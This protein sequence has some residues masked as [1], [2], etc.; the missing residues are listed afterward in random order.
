MIVRAALLL[1][2][3]RGQPTGDEAMDNLADTVLAIKAGELENNFFSGEHGGGTKHERTAGCVHDKLD[4]I[5]DEGPMTFKNDLLVD[6]TACCLPDEDE[7]IEEVLPGC[8]EGMEEAYKILYASRS[9]HEILEKV[10]PLLEK[11]VR[12]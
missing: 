1:A 5:R 2:A 3:V 9:D 4:A 8:I 6:L 12:S 10:A 7:E 11:Y